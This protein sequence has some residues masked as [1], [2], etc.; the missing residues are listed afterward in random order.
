MQV[1][2][3]PTVPCLDVKHMMTYLLITTSLYTWHLKYICS[4]V[5]DATK[6]KEKTICLKK[7]RGSQYCKIDTDIW[8]NPQNEHEKGFEPASL[9]PQQVY[10]I[11]TKNFLKLS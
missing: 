1:Y 3:Q 10:Q 7:R 4:K 5:H 11:E 9:Y 8:R 2:T 6:T